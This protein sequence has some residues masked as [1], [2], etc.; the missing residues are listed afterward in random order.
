MHERTWIV[1]PF[2]AVTVLVL[3]GVVLLLVF[4][5]GFIRYIP[6]SSAGIV[7]K[8]VSSRGSVKSGFI[9][10]RGEAG[11]QPNVLRG[12]WHFFTPFQYKIHTIPLV[13]IPQGTIGYVFARDGASLPSTQT[14][15]G[16]TTADKFQDVRTFL[17][18]GGQRG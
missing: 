3:F 12:G 7:E 16:N 6:N 2:L 17:Q 11:Y 5:S 8:R 18:D 1:L 15:A 13:T 10:L 4:M 9:A 14:L